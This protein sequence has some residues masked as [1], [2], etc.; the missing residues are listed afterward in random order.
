MHGWYAF[1]YEEPS[2]RGQSIVGQSLR[3]PYQVKRR[4]R[5][6]PHRTSQGL[7]ANNMLFDTIIIIKD[8]IYLFV[9]CRGECKIYQ[10][11]QQ[12]G[13]NFYARRDKNW[14][15]DNLFW[16]KISKISN[17]PHPLPL[18]IFWTFPPDLIR[19]S[20]L[21]IFVI[22]NL[23]T[24]EYTLFYKKVVYKKVVLD[25]PKPSESFSTSSKS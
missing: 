12:K 25:W 5:Q 8:F 3:G 6:G 22:L 24:V 18:I 19:T 23:T 1:H 16:S 14:P 9:I 11:Y 17:G 2:F 20:R 4:L 21:S 13:I 7:A 10:R 15:S